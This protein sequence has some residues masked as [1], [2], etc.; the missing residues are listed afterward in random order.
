LI[1]SVVAMS[2]VAMSVVAMSVVAMSAVAMSVDADA[3]APQRR[4]RLPDR[5]STLLTHTQQQSLLL[6]VG[7]ALS[8][9]PFSRLRFERRL[10]VKGQQ[11]LPT[12][13]SPPNPSKFTTTHPR[14]ELMISL[15]NIHTTTALSPPRIVIHGKEGS[16]KTTLAGQFPR[17]VFLQTEDGCPRDL[18]IPTFGLLTKY[19]DVIAAIAAL[20]NERHEYRTVVIDSLDVLEALVWD[21]TC[22]AN[23]WKSIESPA[24]GRGFVEGDKF[25]QDLLAGLDWIRRNRGMIVV[26][27]AHS[28]VETV[29]DPRAQS[30]TAYQLRLHKRGRALVQD[31]ADAIGFLSTEL[32]IQTEDQGFKKRTRADG[33]SARYIHWEGKPA[34]TA[35][36]RYGLPAKMLVPMD[37]DFNKQL[38]PYFPVN[39]PVTSPVTS[40]VNSPVNAGDGAGD[41]AANR[42]AASAPV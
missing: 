38:A 4:R 31:W 37:F 5:S 28:A 22:A 12:H 10:S 26:L 32:V 33:G 9:F 25:W 39:S 36:N 14:G 20:G 1:I 23:N 42:G 21:A 7:E 13:N 34:F 40:P 3:G 27:I 35:K 17:A 6:R 15:A 19:D 18:E 8:P 29:N 30:Y 41:G 2:V 11:Q 16:G 24:Y